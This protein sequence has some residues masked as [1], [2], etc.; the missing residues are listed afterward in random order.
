MS[1]I[2]KFVKHNVSMCI[3]IVMLMMLMSASFIAPYFVSHDPLK[4]NML[5]K[6]EPLSSRHLLGTDPWGRDLLSRM[7]W[8]A[9]YSLSIGGC[10]IFISMVFGSFLGLVG[11]FY[12][13]SRSSSLI[14]WITDVIMSFPPIIIGA[15]VGVLFGPGIFNTIV[16]LSIAFFPRFIRL[17]RAATLSVR[18]EVYIIEAG[19]IGMTDLRLMWVHLVPNMISPIIVMAII[20]TSDAITLE[21]GL[22]FLGLGVPA[23]TPSWGT[24]LQDNLRFIHVKPLAVI[25]PCIAIAWTVQS[26]NLIGDRFRDLLDPKMR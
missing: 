17:A 3:G 20:W 8:G 2:T 25:W 24:I 4:V 15:I 22:S 19:S 7:L 16:A 6:M 1:S 5:E 11:G 14:V 12:P 9:R 18:E 21:V 23:P 10:S 13:F 26:F